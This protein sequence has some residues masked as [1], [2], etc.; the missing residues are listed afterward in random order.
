M[1]D[2]DMKEL[3]GDIRA[4]H[5]EHAGLRTVALLFHLIVL[6]FWD[7]AM[8]NTLSARSKSS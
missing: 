5:C 6:L 8:I 4:A 2:E 1:V 3:N 7:T